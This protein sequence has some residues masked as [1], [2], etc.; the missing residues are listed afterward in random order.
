MVAVKSILK[1]K[2]SLHHRAAKLILSDPSKP[3]DDKL[4]SLKLLPLSKRLKY[5][6][7][8]TMFEVCNGE[9]SENIHS[10]FTMSMSSCGSNNFILP[11]PPYRPV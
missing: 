5:S 6:K 8:V 10:L 7:A 3:T 4:K 1:K 11:R 9:T 2:K